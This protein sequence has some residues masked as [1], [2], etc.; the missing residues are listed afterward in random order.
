MSTQALT[1]VFGSPRDGIPPHQS[2]G[3]DR[4]VM[5]S[6]A[7]HASKDTLEC[8][9]GVELVA[10]ESGLS[11][12]RAQD[13]LTRC[14]KAGWLW[15]K[16]NG[17]PD[18]RIPL[19]RRP[20][21][22]R[23]RRPG[24]DG[25]YATDTPNDEPPDDSGVRDAYTPPEPDGVRD[26]DATGCTEGTR[27]GARSVHPNH[28]GTVIEPLLESAEVVANDTAATGSAAIHQTY[29]A[30]PVT[31]P[32]RVGAGTESEAVRLEWNVPAVALDGHHLADAIL[33]SRM[34]STQLA[35]RGEPGDPIRR[36]LS[37]RWVLGMETMLRIDGRSADEIA[38]VLG[39]LD[40][41]EDDVASFWR[42]NVRSPDKL[43]AKWRQMA[44]QYEARVRR[45]S[46]GQMPLS[47]DAAAVLARGRAA[48]PARGRGLPSGQGGAP[49]G[50]G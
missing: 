4:L 18:E 1:L 40:R 27:R 23:I 5:L 24:P 13:A 9:P 14:V 6:L 42:A 25:V 12:R 47:E 21:L 33:L 26:Q 35:N 31:D 45:R 3:S 38:R 15:R 49:R 48:A 8:Y 39:W 37:K 44:E 7:N 29:V 2:R 41:G 46:S 20:N 28:Q 22:Y 30:V 36:A 32:T 16:I 43:R 50:S 17:A 11:K 10:D 34:L 19:D